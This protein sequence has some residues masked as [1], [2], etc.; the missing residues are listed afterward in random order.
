MIWM[1]EYIGSGLIFV[2]DDSSLRNSEFVLSFSSLTW[3]ARPSS[4][5]ARRYITTWRV[6]IWRNITSQE[7][8]DRYLHLQQLV[9]DQ[10][11]GVASLP[12]HGESPLLLHGPGNQAPVLAS[13]S[14][15][16]KTTATTNNIISN[17]SSNVTID[18]RKMSHKAGPVSSAE[19]KVFWW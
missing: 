6:S 7:L 11:A 10:N 5:S 14:D 15:A 12:R 4:C 1:D 8:V 16:C 2:C 3:I 13:P 9:S 17:N 18:N 19:E